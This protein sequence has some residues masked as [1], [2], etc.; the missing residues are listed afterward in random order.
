ME[1][2]LQ[3]ECDAKVSSDVTVHRSEET[4]GWWA[5]SCGSVLQKEGQVPKR[6]ESAVFIRLFPLK[7]DT[8][9]RCSSGLLA[10]PALAASTVSPE[11]QGWF[12]SEQHP[13]AGPSQPRSTSR[14]PGFAAS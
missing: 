3:T 13:P 14:R 8:P 9:G 12:H 1:G 5:Q 4:N 2:I 10:S 7:T 11:A 6:R